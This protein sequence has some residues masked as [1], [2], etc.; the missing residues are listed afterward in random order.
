MH[1]YPRLLGR[2]M[3]QSIFE[4]NANPRVDGSL[5]LCVAEFLAQRHQQ[6]SLRESYW[7]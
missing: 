3:S 5:S 2:K 4:R 6:L 1:D 7:S